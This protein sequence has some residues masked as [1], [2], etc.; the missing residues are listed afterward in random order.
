MLKDDLG[1]DSLVD[2]V[3]CK[4]LSFSMKH[5]VNSTLFFKAR[6]TKLEVRKK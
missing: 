4:P 5:S 3:T 2:S 6:A 1:E